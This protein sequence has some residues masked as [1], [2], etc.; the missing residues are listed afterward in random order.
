[1]LKARDK[2]GKYRIDG[3]VGKGGFA[4]VYRAYDTI[5]GIPVALKIPHARLLTKEALDDFR[6]EVRITASL[7]HPNILLMKNASFIGDRFVI[8]YPLGESTLAD[9]L[10]RRLTGRSALLLAEQLLEAVAYAHERRIIHCDIKPENVILFPD[11][12]VRLTDFGIA[13]VALKTRTLIGGGTGTFGYLAPEQGIGRPS[14]RSDVFALGLVLYRMFSGCLPE[15]PYD[16]PPPGFD[17]LRRNVHLDFVRFLRRATELDERARF[18]DA[19]HMLSAFRRIKRHALRTLARRRKAK[20]RGDGQWKAIRMREFR[21]RYGRSLEVRHACGKCGGPVS[22]TM[23]HCP[24]CGAARRIFRGTTRF[25]AR[26]R[27]CGRSIKLDW[28]FCAWCYGGRVQQPSDRHY[29][30]VRYSAR[31]TECKGDLMPFMRYCP[32]CRAKVK[33]R[34]KIDEE[35]GKCARCGW[36]VLPDYWVKCPWC[37]KK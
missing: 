17:R 2:L 26:C 10:K 30:D 24:W 9:R 21:R 11:G 18:S 3:R 15:W 19:G 14:L 33:R 8:V 7:D 16:W 25:P 29:S 31:C 34:W 37:G 36:G 1:M 12:R 20:G 5:E 4:T 28:P 23:L 13:K 22:E 6:N 27:R 32:W 35:R